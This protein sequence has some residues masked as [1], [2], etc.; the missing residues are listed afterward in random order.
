MIGLGL[1]DGL[2]GLGGVG[3]HGHLGHVHVA[4]LHG[5]LAEAL[6]L[7]LLTG[8][9]ELR[10]LAD[11][12]FTLDSKAPAGGYQEFLMN[13]ARYARLT[14]EF[15]ERAEVLFARNEEAAKERYAHLM[16]LIDLYKAE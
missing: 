9:G 4:V 11:V 10:H 7:H 15:P 13:E 2:Q 5:D 1:G 12:A 8:S 3:A 16:K 14:R 6:L